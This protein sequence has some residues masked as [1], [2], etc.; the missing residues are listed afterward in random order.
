MS[1][2]PMCKFLMSNL[3]P[4]VATLYIDGDDLIFQLQSFMLEA[5]SACR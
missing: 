5:Q 1:L 2:S 4:C 3:I